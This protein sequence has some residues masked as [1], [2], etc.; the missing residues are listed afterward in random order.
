M[1]KTTWR[2]PL[3]TSVLLL[4][5]LT[6]GAT[7]HAQV[8]I[9]EV[10]YDGGSEFIEFTN[11]GTSPV[12]FAGWSFDDDSRTANSVSLS[13]FGVVAPGESVVL[14]EL[15]ASA[16]RTIWN[17]PASVKVIGG[18]TNNLGRNDEVNIYDALGGQVDRLTYGDQNIP[19][20]PRPQN[21]SIWTT[22]ANL[23]LNNVA[24]WTL[25]T[26]GDAN[27][28]RTGGAAIANPGFYPFLSG[29][30]STPEP[31]PL[32]MVG[33]GLLAFLRRRKAR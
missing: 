10:M 2:Q 6:V 18:N 19:G 8:R 11:I 22:P 29:G 7:A 33:L 12:N 23:G 32:G 25:A 21:A 16:F 28:S 30:V 3:L 31:G 5:L 15:S 9:T 17:L 4:T 14:S 1:R 26:V 13:D 20:T 27:G 24:L